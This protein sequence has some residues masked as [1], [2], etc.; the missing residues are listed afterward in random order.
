MGI[1][2]W[3]KGLGYYQDGCWSDLVEEETA[4]EDSLVRIAPVVFK[5][6]GLIPDL[7]RIGDPLEATMQDEKGQGATE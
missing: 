2:N 1:Q 7:Q 3:P 5:L 4:P 6:D